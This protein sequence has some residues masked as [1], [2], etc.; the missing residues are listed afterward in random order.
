M[1][2]TREHPASVDDARRLPRFREDGPL[3]KRDR[4]AREQAAALLA[5]ISSSDAGVAPGRQVKAEAGDLRG[6]PV[7]GPGVGGA[8]PGTSPESSIGRLDRQLERE[9]RAAA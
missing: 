5:A 8:S 2:R 9:R 4:L 7:I 1:K 3:L 6:I